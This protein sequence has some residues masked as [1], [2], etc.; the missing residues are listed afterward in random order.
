VSL[1]SYT[2]EAYAYEKYLKGFGHEV[3][4]DSAN[5]LD[6]DNDINI[7]FMGLRPVWRKKTGRA[8]DIHEYHSL[9]TGAFPLIKDKIKKFINDKPSGRIFL[10][11]VVQEGMGFQDGIPYIE[12]DM[13]VDD[14]FFQRPFSNPEFD[15]VYAG[16]IAGRKGLIDELIKLAKRKLKLLIV[17]SISKADFEIFEKYKN[18][19]FTGKVHR[20][21]IPKIFKNCRAGLNYTPDIYP[22]NIQTSTKTLEYLA[23]GLV[24]ISNRYNWIESFSK[25]FG[26]LPLW[27][28]NVSDS[29][30]I[31]VSNYFLQKEIF[32]WDSILNKSYFNDFLIERCIR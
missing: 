1:I 9:S 25:K 11:N 24:L 26:I 21:E 15:I 31:G 19:S 29:D 4:L 17:G 2:P 10:N 27:I 14:D 8:I 12:R 28:D 23:A 32:S 30:S 5:S 6:P 22:F 18:V 20:S 7:Y 3:Q 16:S 13:G